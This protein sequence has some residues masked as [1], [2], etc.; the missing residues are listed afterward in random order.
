MENNCS[1]SEPTPLQGDVFDKPSDKRRGPLFF[2]PPE[3][4]SYVLKPKN[5]R[6]IY[7]LDFI[8]KFKD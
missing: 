2:K 4:A 3:R 6:L 7:L 8:Y 5:L 1:G